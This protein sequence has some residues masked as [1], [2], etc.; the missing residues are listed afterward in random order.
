MTDKP[1]TVFEH[2]IERIHQLLEGEPSKVVWNDKIPD[3]H[4]P[5]QLRQIDITI[6]RDGTKVHVECRIHQTPQ[7]V[8]WIEELIGRRLSLGADVIIAVSSSGFTDGAVKKAAAFNIHLRTLEALTDEEVRLWANTAK[9]WLVFYEFTRCRLV[10]DMSCDVPA[11]PAQITREDGTSIPPVQWRALFQ[12]LMLQFDNDPG[13]DNET[14]CFDVEVG[15]PI[16][17]NG[18]KP[19][20]LTLFAAVR[21]LNEPVTLDRMLRYADPSTAEPTLAHVQKHAD[22]VIEIIQSSDGVAFVADPTYLEVPSNTFFHTVNMDFAREVSVQ[23]VM[24]VSPHFALQSDVQIQ[25]VIKYPP[26][27]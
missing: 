1:S 7:D 18:Q 3:P 21:R 12:P 9:V 23:W 8:R 16:L 13:L 27:G 20:K 14:T 2:Q 4:N 15:A 26:K 6:D 19:S 11:A 25:A 10:I 22:N 24:F 17:V 5:D